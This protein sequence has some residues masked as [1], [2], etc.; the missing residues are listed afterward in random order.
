MR[1]L[2]IR[3]N[4]YI[5]I[6]LL[7]K[8]AN[9]TI[10]GPDTGSVEPPGETLIAGDVLIPNEEGATEE[11]KSPFVQYNGIL[12]RVL[13]NDETHG[14][15]II[16]ADNIEGGDVTLGENDPT[17]TAEDFTYDGSAIVDDN[18]KKA[19]ASYNK[20]VDTLYS[21]TDDP[22]STSYTYGFRPVFLLPSDVV[23]SSGDG[24]EGNPYIIE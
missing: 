16:S 11:E 3:N 1:V 14:L 7:N 17:V 6:F 5:L 20:A 24:S 13:Y 10:L 21:F 18:F 2:N 15:Q 22:Y 19:A 12:C 8:D 23:I 4:I 9:G